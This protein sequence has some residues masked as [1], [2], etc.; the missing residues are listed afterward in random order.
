MDPERGQLESQPAGIDFETP[1][2]QCLPDWEMG[3]TAAD[4]YFFAGARSSSRGNTFSL[5]EIVVGT[6]ADSETATPSTSS[7]TVFL[8]MSRK[9]EVSEPASEES[10]QFNPEG[11]GGGPS[12]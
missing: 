11:K 4:G 8:Q 9:S 3:R 10:K 5:P 1:G 6:R 7:K 2:Q 12:L